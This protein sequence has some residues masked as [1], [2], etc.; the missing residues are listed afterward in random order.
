[1]RPFSQASENNKRPI[2]NVLKSAFAPSKRVLE[3][4][5]GT[6]QHAVYFA[7]Y[8]KHLSWLP[9]DRIENHT[10]IQ[11]W[12]DDYQGEN[13]QALRALDVCQEQWPEGFDAVFSANTA[14]I[15]AWEATE[16]M[17]R[18]VAKALPENGVFALYGPFK[19]KGQFTSESNAQFDMFLKGNAPH[20]G[21]RD[22]EKV[23]QIAIDGGLSLIRDHVLPAN[24]QLLVWK[25]LNES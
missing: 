4:G 20:Q 17:L 6:G 18:R 25:K 13:L 5:S 7:E 9:S 12:L 16:L 15:M 21:I 8:L 23:N 22:F 14:H 10:G 19:Y 2:L 24:N 11:L 1:M 3:I